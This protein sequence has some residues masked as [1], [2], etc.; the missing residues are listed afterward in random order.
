MATDSLS[1]RSALSALLCL[2]SSVAMLCSILSRCCSFLRS[3]FAL[4]P[5]KFASGH[6]FRFQSTRPCAS[7]FWDRT[8]AFCGPLIWIVLVSVC[9]R[10][11]LRSSLLSPR[12][13]P[14][15]LPSRPSGTEPLPSRYCSLPRSHIAPVTANLNQTTEHAANCIP[16]C[17]TIPGP[18]EC[19]K[20]LNPATEPSGRR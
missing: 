16:L 15:S 18:A 7:P 12:G 17:L 3:H 6:Q 9:C 10:F 5:S 1:A 20:R 13:R 11:S 8:I 2:L 14:F 19:A 4:V